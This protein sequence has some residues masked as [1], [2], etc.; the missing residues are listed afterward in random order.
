VGCASCHG[1]VD[2]MP[3]TWRVAT[4]QMDWCLDCHRHPER[5]VRRASASSTWPGSRRADQEEKGR[6]LVKEYE[7]MDA[8]HMTSCDT[9]HR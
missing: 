1:R 4:L 6:A 2:D 8:T 3:L 9:C 5:Y 7:I